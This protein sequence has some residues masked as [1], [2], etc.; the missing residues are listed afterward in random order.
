MGK[1]FQLWASKNTRPEWAKHLTDDDWSHLKDHAAQPGE[2][3]TLQNLNDLLAY[4]A[5]QPPALACWECRSIG[6]ALGLWPF[7]GFG[8]AA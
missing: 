2:T 3:P 6:I 8:E 1:V 4:Q 5:Q 7:A